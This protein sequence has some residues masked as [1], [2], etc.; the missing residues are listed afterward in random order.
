MNLNEN[1]LFQM[2][3]VS[4]MTFKAKEMEGKSVVYSRKEVVDEA[5]ITLRKEP[6]ANIV[7]FGVK[8]TNQINVEIVKKL[9]SI[10]GFL[11]H[12][13]DKMSE[14]GRAVDI[15]IINPL[16]GRVMT[17]SSS[18][19][20]VNILRGANDLAVGTDGGGSVIAPAIST[21]LYSIMAKGMGVK[22]NSQRKSTDHIVFTPGIGVISHDYN[23]CIK[24][25][26]MLTNHAISTDEIDV[27]NNHIRVAI[28][29]RGAAILPDGQDMRDII[30]KVVN[31]AI[32][33]VEF[34]EVDFGELD[35]RSS[36]IDA[37]QK[38]I[39]N[40]I[41]IIMTAEGPVDVF[42]IGDSVLGQW[43]KT[44]S[45]IQNKSGKYLLKIANMVD[46]TAVSIPT[47]EL[48][49]GILLVGKSGIETGKKVIALGN[50]IKDVFQIPELFNRYFI[51]SYKNDGLGFI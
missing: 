14:R 16:T 28:P 46:A 51:D 25:V 47:Q 10:E 43:G 33:I 9:Q 17:G 29:K 36:M 37:Y 6:E 27:R 5:V 2:Q 11:F 31:K 3:K 50:I 26:E 30:N 45:S 12:T 35:D 21:G 4:K 15:D 48:G 13:I 19:G 24:A 8:N 7:L 41:D 23:L 40:D 18:G 22:G 39:N 34:V 20:C 49:I 1:L 32:D 38:I 44:G 42:G